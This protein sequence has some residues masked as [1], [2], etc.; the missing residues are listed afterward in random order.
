MGRSGEMV[1]PPAGSTETRR[2]EGGR[3]PTS[4]DHRQPHRPTTGPVPTGGSRMSGRPD[5]ARRGRSQIHPEPAVATPPGSRPPRRRLRGTVIGSTTVLAIA[6]P[7]TLLWRSHRLSWPP[8]IA[9]LRS[10]L[11]TLDHSDLPHLPKP[12][13]LKEF[14]TH[15]EPTGLPD[16]M[17]QLWPVL[18]ALALVLVLTAILNR[19]G[20]RR[21]GRATATPRARQQNRGRS[22]RETDRPGNEPVSRAVDTEP[23]GQSRLRRTADD[24]VKPALRKGARTRTAGQQKSTQACSTTPVVPKSSKARQIS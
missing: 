14:L 8:R 21:R 4:P 11:T 10:D 16:R 7:F 19:A 17:E 3:M 9:G 18:S 23:P 22:G 5:A 15:H 6:V 24:A 20:R 13:D 1:R 2:R 12:S